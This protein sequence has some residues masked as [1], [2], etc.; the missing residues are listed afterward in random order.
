MK[1]REAKNAA[2]HFDWMRLHLFF[3][4]RGPK[5]SMTMGAANHFAALRKKARRTLVA[6]LDTE[7]Q[8]IQVRRDNG[9]YTLPKTAHRAI[10]TGNWYDTVP[11]SKRVRKAWV[12]ASAA[13]LTNIHERMSRE[14]FDSR[15]G[16]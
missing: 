11:K 9:I 10:H 5:D 12:K 8:L 6:S 15:R 2:H 1:S 13:A 7:L 16:V 3:D 14:R 4:R